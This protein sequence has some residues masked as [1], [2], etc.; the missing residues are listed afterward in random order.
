MV[1]YVYEIGG[2]FRSGVWWQSGKVKRTNWVV[3]A[4][5]TSYMLHLLLLLG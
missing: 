3:Y 5:S 1:T 2:E 4:G